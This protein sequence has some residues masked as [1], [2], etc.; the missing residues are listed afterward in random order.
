MASGRARALPGVRFRR[1]LSP[2]SSLSRKKIN[3]QSLGRKIRLRYRGFGSSDGRSIAK[4][5]DPFWLGLGAFLACV[6]V[7]AAATYG[8]WRGL[9]SPASIGEVTEE[10][11][12]RKFQEI[13]LLTPKEAQKSQVVL[14]KRLFSED[15]IKNI[16][17]EIESIRQ[18]NKP[19]VLER[20]SPGQPWLTTV[21]RTTYL[22]TNGLFR[23]QMAAVHNKLR[24]AMFSVDAAN[25]N[26]LNN[27]DPN[28]LT[29]RTVEFHEYWPGGQLSQDLHFDSGS[30]ITA[31]VM[32]EQPGQDFEV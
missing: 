5:A 30:I 2:I 29:F 28:D 27:R 14:V 19:G 17:E 31:D 21:W 11:R 16:K 22:H 3:V 18:S 13:G 4:E 25:W 26:Q 6:G 10:E 1:H 23:S 7:P 8:L 20:G 12:D 9:R 32:L 24:D 15:E